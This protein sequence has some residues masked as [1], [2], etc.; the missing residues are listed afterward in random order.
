[1]NM[2]VDQDRWS[3][4]IR[5]LIPMT[6]QIL[7]VPMFDVGVPV[8]A[9]AN[10]AER[11]DLANLPLKRFPGAV[12]GLAQK[13]PSAG[14]GPPHDTDIAELQFG[15][16]KAQSLRAP[17]A[18]L[19]R[20]VEGLFSYIIPGGFAPGGGGGCVDAI[21]ERDHAF[22]GGG[23]CLRTQAGGRFAR[24]NRRRNRG[25]LRL[26]DQRGGAHH[27]RHQTGSRSSS[28]KHVSSPLRRVAAR[29]KIPW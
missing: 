21:D 4:A 10:V 15:L 26:I 16:A 9:N 29:A 1:M 6:L 2:D 25:G 17:A 22:E 8:D 14:A 27:Q 5:D 23:A 3:S 11:V 24:G 18:L 7:H 12:L 28:R 20:E 13:H 19:A